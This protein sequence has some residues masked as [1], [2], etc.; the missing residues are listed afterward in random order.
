MKGFS[1]N[2]RQE[3]TGKQFS[4]KLRVL[5]YIE[6]LLEDIDAGIDWKRGLVA[7]FEH[8]ETLDYNRV[9]GIV[10][11]GILELVVDLGVGSIGDLQQV[12]QVE[13]SL[14]EVIGLLDYCLHMFTLINRFDLL[15][16][17]LYVEPYIA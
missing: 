1:W 9:V 14:I 2:S 6:S 12:L 4:A 10:K 7:S 11:Q 3:N 16:L 13:Q 15:N 17:S 8:A 5:N